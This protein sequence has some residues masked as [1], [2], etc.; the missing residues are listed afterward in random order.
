VEVAPPV[1]NVPAPI[2]NVPAPIVN[3]DSVQV[4]SMPERVHKI[5]RDKAGKP[6]GS[7]ETNA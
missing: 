4:T 5:V 2:V 3:V 1:V 6:I 7:V